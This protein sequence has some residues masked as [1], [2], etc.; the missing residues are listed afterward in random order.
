MKLKFERQF[1]LK[2]CLDGKYKQWADEVIEGI[3]NQELMV[4]GTKDEIRFCD[5]YRYGEIDEFIKEKAKEKINIVEYLPLACQCIRL[6]DKDTDI[7][8][9]IDIDKEQREHEEKE[10]VIFASYWSNITRTVFPARP[11]EPLGPSAFIGEI[12][13][14]DIIITKLSQCKKDDS[15][16]PFKCLI[17]HELVHAFNVMRLIVPAFL[18]WT[19]FWKK[20]L[21]EGHQCQNARQLTARLKDNIDCYESD[22]ELKELKKYWPSHAEEWFNARKGFYERLR[23]KENT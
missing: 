23:S 6:I 4:F 7:E 13:L 20:A 10:F 22:K 11:V 21:Q 3:E 16:Y 12:V 18:D 15:E 5:V 2:N 9:K 8:L 14:Q 19:N 1:E 17:A